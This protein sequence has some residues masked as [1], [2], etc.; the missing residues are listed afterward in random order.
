[1]YEGDTRAISINTKPHVFYFSQESAIIQ[2][3]LLSK[4][5]GG[6]NLPVLLISKVTSGDPPYLHRS[7]KTLS[8]LRFYTA[9]NYTGCPVDKIYAFLTEFHWCSVQGLV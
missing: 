9:I 4:I 8:P 3:L 6:D 1:M 2:R 7:Q 5:V